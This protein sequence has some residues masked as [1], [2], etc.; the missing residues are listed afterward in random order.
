[1]KV[2]E[3]KK[4]STVRCACGALLKYEESDVE[5]STSKKSI[6]GAPYFSGRTAWQH[7]D[8]WSV[9]CPLCG[10]KI[11]TAEGAWSTPSTTR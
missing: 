10:N 7:R 11:T 3:T 5:K 4:V 2:L 9:K 8:V 1:M 6:E